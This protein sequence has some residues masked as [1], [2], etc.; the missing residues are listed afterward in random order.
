MIQLGHY[1]LHVSRA[2]LWK[3]AQMVSWLVYCFTAVLHMSKHLWNAL[4]TIF[5][6]ISVLCFR[7]QQR[8]LR[9]PL[10]PLYKHREGTSRVQ[11]MWAMSR[12]QVRWGTLQNGHVALVAQGFNTSRLRQWL[13]FSRQHFPVHL[14]EWKLH[15]TLFPRFQ[16][17]I[18]LHWFR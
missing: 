15:W 14:H 4:L 1:F 18:F 9:M 7:W 5:F 13:P 10:S 6:I 8:V 17:T 16:L 11:Y 12:S 3:H 2:L